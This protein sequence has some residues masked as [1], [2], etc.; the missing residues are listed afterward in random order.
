MVLI[1]HQRIQR[2]IKQS[3]EEETGEK[4]KNRSLTGR[5][6]LNLNRE[7]NPTVEMFFE[8]TPIHRIGVGF[9]VAFGAA[10]LWRS[11]CWLHRFLGR[12]FIFHE[13]LRRQSNREKAGDFIFR[14]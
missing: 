14:R 7:C 9:G 6:K 10:Y 11:K 13:P 4:L 5:V 1:I 12:I 2:K 3:E 8:A